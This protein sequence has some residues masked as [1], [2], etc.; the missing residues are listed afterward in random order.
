MKFAFIDTR[1]PQPVITS[2]VASVSREGGG[3]K[4]GAPGIIADH[5]RSFEMDDEP[6]SSVSPRRFRF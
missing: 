3:E 6:R 4:L 2:T 5:S 1:F